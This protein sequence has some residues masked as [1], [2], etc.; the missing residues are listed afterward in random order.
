MFRKK[1]QDLNVGLED[2]YFRKKEK[3]HTQSL[4]ASPLLCTKQV[5]K[6][7]P[8]TGIILPGVVTCP[9]IH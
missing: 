7:I 4:C 6:H 5:A 9:I 1:Q 3:P 2:T 8:D